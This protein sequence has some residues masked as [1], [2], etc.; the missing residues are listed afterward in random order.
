MT[1][2]P[3]LLKI[4]L[5]PLSIFAVLSVSSVQTRD[6]Q[7]KHSPEYR[8]S[9][10]NFLHTKLF[11]GSEYIDVDSDLGEYVL[12]ERLKLAPNYPDIS[13]L[14]LDSRQ[15]ELLIWATDYAVE[16]E[17]YIV[18]LEKYLRSH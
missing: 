8:L 2:Y 16:R 6:Y 7:D 1:I 5:V 18:F 17:A 12:E 4:L 13:S 14:E 9:R 15:P 11:N 10:M 3:Y